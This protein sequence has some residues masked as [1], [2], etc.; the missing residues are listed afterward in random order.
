MNWKKKF[1]GD[2]KFYKLLLAVVVPII[3]QNGITNFVSL[4]DNIMVGQTGTN[5]M[6]GV[7]IA[8]QLMM[9]FNLCIFGGISGAGIFGAQYYGKGDN[10]GVR[11]TF[12]YKFLIC[13]AMCVIGIAVFLGFEDTLIG[14]Y[15]TADS[16]GQAALETMKYGAGYLNIMLVGMIPFALS[17]VYSSTL[18]ECGE[19]MLPMKAGIAAVL[20]NLV[21]NYLLIFGHFGF[22]ELGVY[23][24]A[25]ATVLSR[26]VEMAIIMIWTHAHKKSNEFIVGAYRSMHIPANLM[27]SIT[28]K[29]M[30]LLINEGLW[31]M[32]MATLMQCYSVRGLDVV[33][34]MN[35]SSTIS[36]LFNI[37]FMAMGS[38]VAIIIGQL[39]GAGEMEKAR[40]YDR[41][42]IF[43]AV[44]GAVV[45]GA[46]TAVVA[47]LFPAIYNTEQSVKDL[48]SAFIRI[49]ALCMPIFAFLHTTYF[50]LRSGGKTIIT[51]VFDSVYLWGIS[52]PVAFC[53]SR[54]T[55]MPI[56]WLYLSCNLIDL[57]KC[58]LGFI[59][60]K[61]GVWINNIVE[62]A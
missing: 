20:V 62:E 53:L 22:P 57:V 40:D 18:R 33:A 30:P 50:T 38:A 48:A 59:L 52:I 23:G 39:L 42:L 31:S 14:L 41:K 19:T 61:K 58:T 45:T 27:K 5:Q 54:F 13:I 32:G 3:V 44:A 10:E 46:F 16:T 12:R 34:A 17:Q 55:D 28:I 26:F 4:L 8:N 35:I 1:I 43:A 37:V 60:L 47:P 21:F 24:A 15:L 9:I 2:K 29:G 11:Y 49:S 56:V 25:V 51:F 6:T 36:N 7:A